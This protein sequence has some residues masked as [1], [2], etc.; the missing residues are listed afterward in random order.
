MRNRIVNLVLVGL[1]VGC[2]GASVHVLATEDSD[3]KIGYVV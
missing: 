3:T 1:M 2:M